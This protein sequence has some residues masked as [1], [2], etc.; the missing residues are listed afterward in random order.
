M[1]QT[2]VV[3]DDH[4]SVLE[5]TCSVLQAQYPDTSLVTASTADQVEKLI[6]DSNPSLVIMDLSIPE[7]TGDTSRAENGINLLKTLLTKYPK[8]NFVIQKRPHP[9]PHPP[10]TRNRHPPSRLHHRRQKSTEERDADKVDWALKGLLYTPPE[11]SAGLEIKAEWLQMLQLAFLEG[12]TDKAIAKKMNVS[13]RT[14]RHYWTRAQDALE[15]YPDEGINIRIQTYNRAR[16]TG[17]LD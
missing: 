6:A 14:V 11:M 1:S 16:E 17:L 7:A 10:Q 15:V 4:E 5:G 2:F 13:E 12:M 8:L 3:I 9:H